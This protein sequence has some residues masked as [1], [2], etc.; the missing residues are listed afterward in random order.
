M[1]LRPTPWPSAQRGGSDCPAVVSSAHSSRA[2][3]C[4]PGHVY[5]APTRRAISRRRLA[6][7]TKALISAPATLISTASSSPPAQSL[8]PSGR[9]SSSCARNM[10]KGRL[11]YVEGRFQSHTWEG[12]DG[13]KR[14]T[15][16]VVAYRFQAMSTN[17]VAEAVA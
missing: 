6:P 1:G 7:S 9:P 17:Q 11:A 13:S 3:A 8:R 15:V 5:R 16:E 2:Q 12:A 10:T 14:R 4:C